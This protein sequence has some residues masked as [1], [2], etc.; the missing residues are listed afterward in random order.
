MC[1]M[2][3]WAPSPNLGKLYD[4]QSFREDFLMPFLMTASQLKFSSVQ[5]QVP[6]RA[7]S[8]STALY[9]SCTPISISDSNSQEQNL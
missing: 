2:K 8:Q 5:S 4:H 1:E 7:S 6:T 9:F 3:V